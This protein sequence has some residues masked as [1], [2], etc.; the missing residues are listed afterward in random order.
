MYQVDSLDTVVELKTAPLSDIGA[1]LPLVIADDYR[2]ILEYLISE[3]D[4]NWDGTYVNVVSPNTECTVAIVRF[5]HPYAHF[6]GPP[7]D[8]AFSGHPLASRGLE[9]YG[10]FEIDK[11]SWIRQLERMNSVHPYHDRNRFMKSK[12]HFVFAFHDTTF[13]CVA[14]GFDVSAHKG[15]ILSSV[16][17]IVAMLEEDPI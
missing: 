12:R 4:P 15:S 10:V 7:N 13:E 6:L 2:L 9:P 17:R 11:S 8:E 5:H 14:E 1:P 16:E 3:P